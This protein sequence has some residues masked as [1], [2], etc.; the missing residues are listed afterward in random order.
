MVGTFGGGIGRQVKWEMSGK[1]A[2]VHRPLSD[3]RGLSGRNT[4]AAAALV[5]DLVRI[6]APMQDR[7]NA[8]GEEA[9]D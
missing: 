6:S 8:P 1:A 3:V 5:D 7:F 9:G 4:R 2:D